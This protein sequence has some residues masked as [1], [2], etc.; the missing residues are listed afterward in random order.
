MAREIQLSINFTASK[1]GAKIA[2]SASM[3]Q[4]MAGDDM[5]QATQ[6]ISTTSE[7]VSFG[8]ITG[9]PAQ[10]FIQNLDSTNFVEI[11]G[12]SGLTVFK[13]KLLPGKSTIIS[14]S[15]GTVYAKADTASVRIL[16]VAAEA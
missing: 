5:I 16:I 10:V 15:S 12:D 13:L 11:G 2:A 8:E 6:V 7:V 14:P 9:A 3:T 4:D 1:N